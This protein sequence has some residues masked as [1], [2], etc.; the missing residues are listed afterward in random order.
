LLN[1]LEGGKIT[2]NND[3]HMLQLVNAEGKY[4]AT[5]NKAGFTWVDYLSAENIELVSEYD[6]G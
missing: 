2:I 4:I 1:E 5:F 6:A 3:D